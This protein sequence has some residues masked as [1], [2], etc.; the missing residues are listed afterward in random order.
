MES[1]QPEETGISQYL[2]E[3]REKRDLLLAERD[4]ARAQGNPEL[5]RQATQNIYTH[6]FNYVQYL[7]D[8]KGICLTFLREDQRVKEDSELERIFNDMTE[9]YDKLIIDCSLILNQMFFALH[10]LQNPDESREPSA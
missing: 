6:Y 8:A 3:F 2:R 4:I 5:L 10:G 7:N 1:E 9:V